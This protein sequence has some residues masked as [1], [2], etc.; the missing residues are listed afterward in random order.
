[1]ASCSQPANVQHR[2]DLSKCV[3]IKEMAFGLLTTRFGLRKVDYL[4]WET[5]TLFIVHS[6]T[7]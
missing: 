5:I 1:M 4:V 6:L 3:A 7:Y 2:L